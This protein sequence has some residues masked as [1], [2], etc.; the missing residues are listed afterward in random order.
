MRGLRQFSTSYPTKCRQ[1]VALATKAGTHLLKTS[2][3]YSGCHMKRLLTR[4]ETC[5][6]VT[7]CHASHAKPG[8]ATCETSK[9]ITVAKLATGTAIRPSHKQLRTVV[10]GCELRLPSTRACQGQKGVALALNKFCGLGSRTAFLFLDNL[11]GLQK[12]FL[13][14]IK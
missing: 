7:K 12:R 3:K 5:W 13:K 9:M 14:Q 1:S 8:Y 10:G 4:C 6:N 2:R 11:N